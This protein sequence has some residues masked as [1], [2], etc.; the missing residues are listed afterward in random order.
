MDDLRLMRVFREV[1][2]RGSFSGAAEALAYTQP[3]VSQQV[4]RLESQVGVRLID[5]EPK[6]L[7]L[8]PAGE[9]LLRHTE[10]VLAQLAE[11]R[12]ELAEVAEGARGRVRVAS[13]PSASGTFVGPALAA[14]RRER[15]RVDAT[16]DIALPPEAV[17]RVR[18]GDVEIGISQED[19]FG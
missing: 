8:T 10:T 19:G 2:L 6:G 17:D 9:V 1:A 11:A 7:R 3:A 12:A 16:L 13:M 15:P 14:F 5:R 4:A 18:S